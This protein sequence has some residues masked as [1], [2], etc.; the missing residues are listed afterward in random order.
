VAL[1]LDTFPQVDYEHIHAGLDKPLENLIPQFL[2]HSKLAGG[3]YVS[4]VPSGRLSVRS[5]IVPQVQ[6]VRPDEFYTSWFFHG[7]LSLL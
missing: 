4:Q 1:V 2:V 7:F 6:Q 3:A 5:E